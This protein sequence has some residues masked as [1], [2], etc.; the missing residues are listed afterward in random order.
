MPVHAYGDEPWQ[1]IEGPPK[2]AP[3]ERLELS[4]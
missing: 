2:T 3:G 1:M 4:T